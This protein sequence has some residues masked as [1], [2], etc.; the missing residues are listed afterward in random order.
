A[1]LQLTPLKVPQNVTPK[2]TPPQDT[3]F[4]PRLPKDGQAGDLFAAT[5]K[6]GTEL[7]QLWFCVSSRNDSNTAQWR[8]VIFGST[9]FA[10]DA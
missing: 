1:Q 4:I 10:G 3:K 5:D 6:R 8:Q 2:E 7:C 9:V